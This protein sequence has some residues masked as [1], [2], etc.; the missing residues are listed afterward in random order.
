MSNKNKKN[1][2]IWITLVILLVLTGAAGS[3]FYMKK[4]A[5][6]EKPK[7]VIQSHNALQDVEDLVSLRLYFP[8]N[9]KLQMIEKKIPK[10][11]HQL[12]IAEAVLEEFFKGAGN[13][14]TADVP[15]NV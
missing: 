3:Y 5:D 15:Q 10:R 11:T 6:S 8:I 4:I 12:S 7:T 14:Y 2:K 9:D 13:N 1:R